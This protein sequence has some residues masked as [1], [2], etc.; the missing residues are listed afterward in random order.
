M[1]L[2][3]NIVITVHLVKVD[4]YFQLLFPKIKSSSAGRH[5]DVR[6]HVTNLAK[7]TWQRPIRKFDVQIDLKKSS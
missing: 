3:M 5:C 4:M 7:Q 6:H 1:T 2:S